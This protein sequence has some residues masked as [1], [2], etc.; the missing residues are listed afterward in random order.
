M[1]INVGI[2]FNKTACPQRPLKLSFACCFSSFEDN[3]FFTP[4][5]IDVNSITKKNHFGF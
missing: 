3:L 5:L 1:A 2:R 4:L